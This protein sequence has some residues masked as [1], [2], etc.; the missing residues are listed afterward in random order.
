MPLDGKNIKV[1]VKAWK[2]TSLLAEASEFFGNQ[3][4]PFSLVRI[5]PWP[6]VLWC[7]V[8][9]NGMMTHMGWQIPV[10]HGISTS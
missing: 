3:V 5:Q 7:I 4:C 8:G 9:Y 10:L 2:E 1:A 6:I